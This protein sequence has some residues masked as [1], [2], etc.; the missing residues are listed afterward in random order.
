[1]SRLADLLSSGWL[2]QG[3]RG[4]TASKV[5]STE[6]TTHDAMSSGEAFRA[7]SR[8]TGAASVSGR[9]TTAHYSGLRR[10][11]R[12]GAEPWSFATRTERRLVPTGAELRRYG[13][14]HTSLRRGRE[15]VEH[16]G[17]W[18]GTESRAVR[19]AGVGLL[20]IAGRSFVWERQHIIISP[21]P[22]RPG[23][24]ISALLFPNFFTVTSGVKRPSSLAES[25]IG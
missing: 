15:R 1:M 21:S 20:H 23:H 3:R 22:Q 6:I 4:R 19:S 18:Q 2:G 10:S 9:R 8:P 25:R 16:F 24:S 13:K 7:N 11:Y 17:G 14:P 5:T 12:L